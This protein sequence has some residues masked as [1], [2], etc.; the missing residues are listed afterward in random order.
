MVVFFRNNHFNTLTK[1]NGQLYLLVTDFGY[2]DVPSVVWEK[3]DVI[4]GDTEYATDEFKVPPPVDHH[5]SD[6]AT[7]EQL[8]AN[9]AQSQADFQ[10]ALQLSRESS[11][12]IASEL[13][14]TTA[15]AMDDMERARQASLWEHQQHQQRRRTSP[16]TVSPSPTGTSNVPGVTRSQG[17]PPLHPLEQQQGNQQ[18]AQMPPSTAASAA[19]TS[20]GPMVAVGIPAANIP[21]E[22]R[23]LLF[24]MQLQRQ[25]EAERQAAVATANDDHAS[26]QLAKTMERQ[27]RDRQQQYVSR[28]G[29]PPHRQ[30]TAPAAR[31]A[32]STANTN[33]VIS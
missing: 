32:K 14:A 18:H 6:A 17:P 25:E 22:E 26:R 2:A 9:T 29:P 20:M 19:E 21:Q 16:T 7:G 10:L 15:S 27:E 24:A 33:C 23:D 30:P 28:P 4:D 31:P 12:P 8:L 13:P 3:L 5:I 1:H 11:P